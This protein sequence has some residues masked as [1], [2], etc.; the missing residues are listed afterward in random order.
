MMSRTLWITVIALL[1]VGVAGAGPVVTTDLGPV[2]G[3]R[4]DGV[5][6]F[7]GLRFAAPPTGS[8]RF[9]APRSPPPWRTPAPALSWPPPRPQVGDGGIRLG[10]EDCLFL[11]LWA[12]DGA[13]GLPVLVFLHGGG[14][15]RGS[16][17][18]PLATGTPLYDGA[19]LASRGGVVVVTVQYRLGAL[20]FVALPALAAAGAGGNLGLADQQLALYSVAELGDGRHAWG[21]L[22]T[23]AQFVCPAR[24]AAAAV[25]HRPT[26]RAIARLAMA[27]GA[28]DPR[29]ARARTRTRTRRETK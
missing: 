10:D 18:V 5:A 27:S 14:H 8:H 15:V 2:E 21:A 3:E 22:T 19:T 1:V 7:L 29:R 12:P 20:G 28:C 16:T 26:N 6:R 17:S 4:L 9:E 11:N 23:D 13:A 25:G 24:A